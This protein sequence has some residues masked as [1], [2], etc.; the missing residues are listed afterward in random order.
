MKDDLGDLVELGGRN[1]SGGSNGLDVSLKEKRSFHV[2]NEAGNR[3]WRGRCATD[4]LLS[5]Q[6]YVD[7]FPLRPVLTRDWTI[8]PLA[9]DSAHGHLS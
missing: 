9:L 6:Q 3:V 7:T 1:T 8:D 5:L 4:A 2:L